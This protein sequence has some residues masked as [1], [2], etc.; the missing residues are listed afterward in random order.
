[1]VIVE[2][3]LASLVNEMGAKVCVCCSLLNVV[4][5]VTNCSTVP[6]ICANPNSF[7]IKVVDPVSATLATPVPAMVPGSHTL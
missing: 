1:M 3:K 6:P 5:P 7:R 2:S 4:T